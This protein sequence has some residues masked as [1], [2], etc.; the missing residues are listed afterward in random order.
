LTGQDRTGQDDKQNLLDQQITSGD[1]SSLKTQQK[2]IIRS[3]K[4]NFAIPNIPARIH[5]QVGREAKERALE[6]DS[7][8]FC[9]IHRRTVQLYFYLF[10][11]LLRKSCK[12]I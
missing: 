1:K 5:R 3:P 7:L 11:L 2:V 10:N 6:R 8:L 12:Y 9:R 4:H